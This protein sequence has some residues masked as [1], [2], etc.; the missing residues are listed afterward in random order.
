MNG[1]GG[2]SAGYDSDGNSATVNGFG[3][4]FGGLPVKNGG[5]GGSGILGLVTRYTGPGGGG[6]SNYVY[7]PGSFSLGT[8][9]SG[10]I[11]ISWLAPYTG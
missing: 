10:A 5:Y 8:G 6:S 4:V 2:G 11:R 9:A 3:I 7:P 1:G